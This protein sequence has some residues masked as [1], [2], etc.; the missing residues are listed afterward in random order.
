MRRRSGLLL[1]A[2]GLCLTSLPGGA[3]LRGQEP[4]L[5]DPAGIR[6]A[7]LL[8]G[9]GELPESLL[10]AFV[11]RAGGE[12][13]RLVVLGGAARQVDVPAITGRWKRRGAGQV[14]VLHAPSREEALRPEFSASLDAATGVWIPGGQQRRLAE[15]YLGTP[16]EAALA[17]LLERGHPIG[18]TSAGAAIQS[19]VMI[20]G[21]REKPD[22]ATGLDLLP[23]AIVDQHFTR[24]QRL[25]R[26]EIAVET[27]RDRVGLGIDEGTALWVEGRRGRV[28]GRGAV[29]VL[30]PS[31]PDREALRRRHEAGAVIDW[32]ALRRA[33]RERARGTSPGTK[34]GRP[35]LESGTLIIIGG[36]GVPPEA[37]E[38]F[39][40]RAGGPDAPLVVIPTAAGGPVRRQPYGLQMLRR[41]GARDV[42]VID[43][44]DPG[45]VDAPGVLE[46]LRRARGVWLGGGRQ[47]RLVD[48]YDGTRAGELL[49]GVLERG[50]VIAG[51]SAGASI[52]A[53]YLVRGNPL[54]NQ[55]MMAEGY[56]RGLGFLKG[57]AVDQHFTQR[58]RLP[59]L[60]GVIERFPALL[61]I[62]IDESTALVVEGS[63]ARVTG[64]HRVF[65]LDGLDGEEGEIRRV[66]LGDG[67]TLD[68]LT[69]RRIG[70][71]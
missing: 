59:D 7:L 20:Q 21:G 51:S 61:G 38:L 8:A 34:P 19:R 70:E 57:V 33:A 6:G 49:H 63:R 4:L 31:S 69:R 16:V 52:Q 48:A 39:I 36:G 11:R 37:L 41:A 3:L 40:E 2:L 10:E 55:D 5:T 56:E 46:V 44:R 53:E 32:T 58:G 64:R 18:G 47:W 71:F 50:G 68:L 26:L 29:S 42:T 30:L 66:S 12:E 43:G 62:G 22:L 35:R 9:G 45:S 23:G 17:R 60:V 24:R 13:A 27:T 54:G 28:F 67:E 25:G 65:F 14:E 1:L 15:L